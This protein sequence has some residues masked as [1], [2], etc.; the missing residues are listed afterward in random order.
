MNDKKLSNI[1]LI[2]PLGSGKTSIGKELATL[3]HYPFYDSDIEIE[4]RT[5]V[6]ISWIFE[7]EGEAGFRKRETAMIAE[8]T[9]LD[10]IVLATGG[11]SVIERNNR[12]LLKANGVVVYLKVGVDKQ[13]IRTQRKKE[14]RP[15]LM[16]NNSKQGLDQ[17]NQSREAWYQEIAELSYQTDNISL[18][19]LAKKIIDDIKI[20]RDKFT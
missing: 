1:Y 12:E 15:L 2:G 6:E 17:L 14:K 13:F 4:K 20:H 5:G 3:L 10:H 7:R 9:Q 16:A 8:L 11:G 19:T 18:S